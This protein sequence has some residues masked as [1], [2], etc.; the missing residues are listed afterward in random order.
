MDE[1]KKTKE[2]QGAPRDLGHLAHILPLVFAVYLKARGSLQR[3]RYLAVGA[4]ESLKRFTL[5][6]GGGLGGGGELGGALALL[7][8]RFATAHAEQGKQQG[9]CQ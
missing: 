8:V 1:N 4:D 3:G 5:R 7:L 2:Q 9:K 6:I